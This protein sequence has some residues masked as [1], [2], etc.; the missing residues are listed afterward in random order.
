MSVPTVQIA[1]CRVHFDVSDNDK[2]LKQVC[3]CSE[4]QGFIRGLN[5]VG[6]TSSIEITN[7]VIARNT[8]LDYP[9]RSVKTNLRLMST[10]SRT[11][12]QFEK[13]LQCGN[14]QSNNE[15]WVKCLKDLDQS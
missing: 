8:I 13:M 9:N 4:A 7:I 3:D 5:T 6:K 15:T 2:I 11:V 1:D 10:D 14:D 12:E